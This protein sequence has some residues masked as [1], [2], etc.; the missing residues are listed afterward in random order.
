MEEDARR[1]AACDHGRMDFTG[2]RFHTAAAT[3]LPVLRALIDD[4]HIT[5]ILDRHLPKHP[6]AR[7]SDAQ[8]VV[9][10]ILNILSG[11]L[12]LWRMAA[13]LEEIDLELVLGE[14][15]QVNAFHDTRLGEALDHID[16][17]GT[18]V[19]LSEVAVGWVSR[20]SHPHSYCVH[21]DTSSVSVYGRYLGVPEPTPTHGFSKDKR[22]DLKQLIFGLSV[23]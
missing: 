20:P 22:P 18:D 7:V 10:L 11:R 5:D 9:A 8:C 15:V 14:G 21:L 1:T 4:L 16:A 17:L 3:H 19:V 13:W 23:A 12:A 6:L 2:H